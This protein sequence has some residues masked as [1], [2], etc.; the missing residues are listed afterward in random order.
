MVYNYSIIIGYK[1]WEK[2][3]GYNYSIIIIYKKEI[4]I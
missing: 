4:I 2:L 1:K 3:M